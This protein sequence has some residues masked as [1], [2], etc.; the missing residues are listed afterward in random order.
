MILGVSTAQILLIAPSVTAPPFDRMLIPPKKHP[1]SQPR[2]IYIQPKQ[3]MNENMKSFHLISR[4]SKPP[5][6]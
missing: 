3:K 5:K 6:T 4:A 1:S 2:S